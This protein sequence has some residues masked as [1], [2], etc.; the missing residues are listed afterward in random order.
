MRLRLPRSRRRYPEE[1]AP[2]PP[3]VLIL[4]PMKDARRTLPVYWS[5][6]RRVT[7]PRGRISLG[8]LESDSSDGTWDEVQACLP[9][10]QR[11]FR[12]AL[13]WKRDFGYRI[14]P[15][16][17]RWED[18]IQLARR[19]VLAR[20]RNHLLFHALDDEDWVLWMDA[21]LL[22]YPPDVIERLLAVGRDVVQPHCVLQYGGPTYDRN[23]WVDQG[24]SH[25]D[26][27][28]DH[29]L[30]RLDSVGGTMLL[31]KA[32]LHRDG[33]IFPPFLYG[34]D[35]P[36]VRRGRGEIETEGLGSLAHDMGIECWGLPNL[37]VL[38]HPF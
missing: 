32:D 33:L 30:V 34:L 28:R 9:V 29:D 5:L 18:S 4:T 6:L 13:A 12:R 35:N 14:P 24:R 21:D 15:G 16:L 19:A 11:E 22:D 10:L 38:H 17:P 26:R 2:P 36:L 37:E 27:L 3:R 25:M 8:F 7:Y 31:V 20:S 1:N 23:A